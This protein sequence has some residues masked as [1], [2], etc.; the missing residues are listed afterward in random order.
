MI[1][2]SIEKV[3]FYIEFL[4]YM[5]NYIIYYLIFLEEMLCILLSYM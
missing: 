3:E 2:K 4:N 5:I 1:W